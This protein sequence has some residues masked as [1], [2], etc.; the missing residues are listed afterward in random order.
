M[1]PEHLQPFTKRKMAL[2]YFLLGYIDRD[3]V[4]VLSQTSF[5][6]VSDIYIVDVTTW[7]MDIVIVSKDDCPQS[8]SSAP[9]FFPLESK[10]ILGLLISNMH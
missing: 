5:Y 9:H 1:L 4:S 7:S 2:D 8:F 10:L 3:N 6:K